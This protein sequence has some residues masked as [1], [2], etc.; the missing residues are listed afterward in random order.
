[1]QVIITAA[2]WVCIAGAVLGGSIGS[3]CTFNPMGGNNGRIS[4]PGMVI[5]AI[6]GGLAGYGLGS[7]LF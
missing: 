7:L 1:M 3:G 4:G 5:G 6:L 2:G